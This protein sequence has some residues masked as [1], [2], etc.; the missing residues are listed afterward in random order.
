MK[1]ASIQDFY[2]GYSC[3]AII[4][5]R[6]IIMPVHEPAIC[7]TLRRRLNFYSQVEPEAVPFKMQPQTMTVYLTSFE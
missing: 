1:L 5:C 6:D 2:P 3:S 7:I 4:M